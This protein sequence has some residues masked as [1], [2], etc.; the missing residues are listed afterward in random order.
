MGGLVSKRTLIANG[1]DRDIYGRVDADKSVAN[2]S[3]ATHLRLPPSSAAIDDGRKQEEEEEEIQVQLATNELFKEKL[4]TKIGPGFR[5]CFRTARNA[6]SNS[7]DGGG[8]VYVS[9]ALADGDF[10]C[11]GLPVSSSSSSSGCTITVDGKGNL[12]T[13]PH[14][15]A[16]QL[17]AKS[18][19]GE[20][21]KD[22]V[23]D[24]SDHHKVKKNI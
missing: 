18:K 8:E 17:G 14:S 10:I 11:R 6:N 23:V 1:Y 2:K 16:N 4:F 21:W 19:G 12:K 3:G 5:A 15:I 13:A 24:A 20:A 7:D 9:I 22:F